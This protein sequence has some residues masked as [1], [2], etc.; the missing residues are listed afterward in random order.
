MENIGII[1]PFVRANRTSMSKQERKERTEKLD[2]QLCSLTERVKT[3]DLERVPVCVRLSL[4]LFKLWSHD[5][6]APFYAGK[7]FYNGWTEIMNKMIEE[8]YEVTQ[9]DYNRMGPDTIEKL[10]IDVTIEY[11]TLQYERENRQSQKRRNRTIC[12][13]RFFM[14]GLSLIFAINVYGF[15]M[16]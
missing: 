9:E 5:W 10:L 15:Y 7:P 16:H 13:N 3:C 4:E 14:I 11:A 12:L 8:L 1:L 2:E 6:D